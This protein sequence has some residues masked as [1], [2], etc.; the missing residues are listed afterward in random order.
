MPLP[1]VRRFI[2]DAPPAQAAPTDTSKAFIIGETELGGG[3]PTV[4]SMEP[5]ALTSMRG[6]THAKLGRR[7]GSAIPTWDAADVAFREG[8]PLV[9]VSRVVGTTPVAASATFNGPTSGISVTVRASSVGE[10]ANGAANG[11]TAQVTQGPAGAAERIL[12]IAL[13]GEEVE[14]SPVVTTR[15][16]LLAWGDEDLP[17]DE[18]GSDWVVIEAGANAGLPEVVA[19]TNLT[20]GDADLDT[21]SA[22]TVRQALDRCGIGLGPGQVFIPWRTTAAYHAEA[23]EHCLAHDRIALLD[24]AQSASVATLSALAETSRDLGTGAEGVPRMGGL[25]GQYAVGP[26]VTPGTTRTVPWS[27]VA[28]G[29]LALATSSVGHANVQPVGEAGVPRWAT[30]ADRYFT[31]TPDG[32]SDADTLV[33]AGVNVV[34]ERFDGPRTYTFDSLDDPATSEWGDLAHSNYVNSVVSRVVEIGE[35]MR[36]GRF[37]LLHAIPRFGALTR[38]LL[39][40]DFA[41]GALHGDSAEDAA[42]VDVETVN[43]D[44]TIADGELNIGLGLRAG[45]HVRDVSIT[46]SKVPSG[47]AV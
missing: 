12:I 44:E 47:Q 7:T 27:I 2:V 11:L 10:W 6:W 23:L 34:V 36:D 29:Q 24:G 26:G 20:G 40:G 16:E 31:E 45:E 32:D 4:A 19:A 25:W 22:T 17:L 37:N 3:F 42:R 1:R 21:V 30:R 38:L 9:Y 33:D 35:R 13:D 41:L 46:L 15:A 28:G 39:A 18:R 43:D 14:R 8:Y 5:V